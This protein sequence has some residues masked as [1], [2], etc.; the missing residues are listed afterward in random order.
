MMQCSLGIPLYNANF[1]HSLVQCQF[2]LSLVYNAM[3]GHSLVQCVTMDFFSLLIFEYSNYSGIHPTLATPEVG[4]HQHGCHSTIGNI[5]L[6]HLPSLTLTK[7]CNLLVLG[8][9]FPS[10]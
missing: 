2:G 3:F 9:S 10:K 6:G 4:I 8:T 1:G 5:R 7:E